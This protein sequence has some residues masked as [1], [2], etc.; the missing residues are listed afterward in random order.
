MNFRSLLS[1]TFVIAAQTAFFGSVSCAQGNVSTA[2]EPE[3]RSSNSLLAMSASRLPSEADE[4]EL[5]RHGIEQG[6]QGR[7]LYMTPKIVALTPRQ[8]WGML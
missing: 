3:G 2:N 5:R 1:A 6:W 7:V 4:I 8:R